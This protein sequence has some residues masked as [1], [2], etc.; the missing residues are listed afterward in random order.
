MLN[1][2]TSASFSYGGCR[3]TAKRCVDTATGKFAGWY[4][5]I[6][7]KDVIFTKSIN[8]FEKKFIEFVDNRIADGKPCPDDFGFLG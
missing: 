3:I 4:G 2:M 5:E 7:D 1:T 8:Q 6:S